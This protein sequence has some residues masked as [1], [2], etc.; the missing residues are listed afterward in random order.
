[1]AC[2]E[3]VFL[4]L[5]FCPLDFMRPETCSGGRATLVSDERITVLA[6]SFFA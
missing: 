6:S 3:S 4:F 5:D 2:R 1:M